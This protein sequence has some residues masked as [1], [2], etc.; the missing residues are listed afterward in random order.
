MLRACWGY[1][2][3]MLRLCWRSRIEGPPLGPCWAR[4]GPS[5]AYL[6][7]TLGL[8]WLYVGLMLAYV[9]PI[10]AYV[11]PVLALCWPMLAYFGAYVE[12]MVAICD[13]ISVERPPR[14]TPPRN[15][16]QGK[17]TFFFFKLSPTKKLWASKRAKHRKKRCFWDLR[18]TKH[19][20]LRGLP[21][22]GLG[23]G[24]VGGSSGVGRRQAASVY[25]FWL[26]PKALRAAHGPVA[27]ARI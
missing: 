17:T 7:L 18:H 3:L 14:R 26:P 8:C 9:S 24:W 25:N 13:T 22:L 23:R 2:A 1:V 11:V 27:G 20:K 4:L 19:C 6:G 16:K 5:W 15:Q 12:A 21:S 10:L